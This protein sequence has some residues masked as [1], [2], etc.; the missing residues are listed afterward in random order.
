M[1][2]IRVLAIIEAVTVTGPAKNLLQ[3][4][5]LAR[6]ADYDPG[7][8]LSI[9]TFRRGS[10]PSIFADAVSAAR[11]PL[12]PIPESGRFDRGVLARLSSLAA[13]LR[14]DIV[15][16]HA[17]K[18]HFLVR[19]AGLDRIAPWIAF[20]HGYTR[21]TL[22]MRFYNQLDSW[23]L[24][25]ARRVVT[26]SKPFRDE[27]I[28]R[29]VRLECIAIVH[30]AIGVGRGGW[31]REESAALRARLGIPEGRKVVLIVGRL[32]REKDH[33]VLIS[34][35]H[36]LRKTAD[37]HL[38]IVG[39]G[40]ER[41]PI[42]AHI[43]SLGMWGAVTLTGQ[44]PSAEPYYGLADVAVLSSISEGSPN[45]LLEAMAFRVPVVA[46]KVG[47]IPEIV[48]D[49]ESA[50]LVRPSDAQALHDAIRHLLTNPQDAKRLSARAHD[51]AAMRHTPEARAR[52]L[53]EIYRGVLGR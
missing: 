28:G 3:F 9:A 47:G 41:G 32:S 16:S 24:R 49:G 20:H 50:L 14:P 34:A 21:P 2:P 4:G 15:Q 10:D 19:Q 53:I 52:H 31:G 36:R 23:S 12:H 42:E 44:T 46:T 39:D 6:S 30:N 40:P 45:A 8:E 35:V 5:I 43:R 29:G 26:V 33:W 1:K 38:L 13:E 51:L 48:A 27:L 11:L 17:V 37:V 22:T 7:V 18:G 25:A